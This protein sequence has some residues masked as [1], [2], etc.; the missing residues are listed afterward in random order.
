[1]TDIMQHPEVVAA[2]N[3]VKLQISTD[4]L[5]RM[6]DSSLALWQANNTS[7]EAREH[8]AKYEWQRRI[9]ERQMKERYALDQKLAKG[10]R[11]WGLVA[12]IVGVIGT[13][14]GVWLGKYVWAAPTVPLQPESAAISKAPTQPPVSG[15]SATSAKKTTTE[16][17]E[18]K[19]K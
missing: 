2:S 18:K 11:W 19:T 9:A 10:N 12:S 13:L 15:N 6:S 8:L 3:R 7:A 17:P 4:E 14:L 16:Q 1:M 5:A